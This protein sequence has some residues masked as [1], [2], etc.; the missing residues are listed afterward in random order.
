M[1]QTITR[2][3]G[4]FDTG[5]MLKA[6]S[7][8]ELMD[9]INFR[10]NQKYSKKSKIKWIWQIQKIYANWEKSKDETYAELHKQ[11]KFTVEAK[12]DWLERKYKN[13]RLSFHDFEA[14]LWKITYDAIEYHEQSGDIDTEFTLVET[15]ELFWKY[16]IKDYIKSCLYTEKH[17]PWYTASSL[18]ANFNQYWK[19]ET[20]GP[21]KSYIHKETVTSMFKDNGL[22][23]EER[24]L[25]ELIYDFPSGSLREWGEELGIKHP[26][27][28]RRRFISLQK[29]LEKYNPF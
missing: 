4:E 1:N 25:L 15:L 2:S 7:Y 11:L 14:E 20:P 28:V 5:S 22:T 27:T 16:R 24:Q 29:K 23:K 12:A 3:F 8:Q 9:K 10:L 18:A 17:S 6:D 26:E 19:D 13:T 21:E